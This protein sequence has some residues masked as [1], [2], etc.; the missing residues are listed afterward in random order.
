MDHLCNGIRPNN[1][2]KTSSILIYH[3]YLPRQVQRIGNLVELLNWRHGK[4]IHSSGLNCLDRQIIVW[5][6]PFQLCFTYKR[7]PWK[8]QTP[9]LFWRG[10][11]EGGGRRDF[12]ARWLFLFINLTLFWNQTVAWPL[13]L[14]LSH[15]FPTYMHVWTRELYKTMHTELNRSI[16]HTHA[17]TF[18]LLVHKLYILLAC[19][20]CN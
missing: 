2:R 3:N 10:L 11:W 4:M 15:Y 17:S 16:T 8:I 9:P 12:L 18:G 7:R 13:F 19:R 14:P 20:T 6:L 5:I 1:N